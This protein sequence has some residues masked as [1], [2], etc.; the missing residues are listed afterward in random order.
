MKIKDYF[1]VA[2]SLIKAKLF[3]RRLPIVVNWAI[4]Y[5]CN[6]RCLYCGIRNISAEEINRNQVFSFI[7]EM[8]QMGTRRI[9]FTGGEPLLREDIGEILEYSKGKNIK[10][11]L[12]SNG[13]LVPE[14]INL[15]KSLDLLSLSLDGDEEVQDTIRQEGSYQKV[16]EAVE[17]AR[18]SNLKIRIITVI[19]KV[20]LNSVDF[21]IDKANEIGAFVT[22]Q[23]ATKMLLEAD[24]V[25][26]IAPSRE[27]YRKVI[28]K[29]ISKKKKGYSIGNSISG[30][31]YLSH[32]P[33]LAGI[34]CVNGR[35][36]CRLEPDGRLYGCGNFKSKNLPLSC[37]K[38]GFK[39]AFD[40]LMPV[41]CK[42]CWCAAMVEMNYLFS[43]RP[44]AVLNIL[45]L[46]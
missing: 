11:A 24:S 10:T 19:S 22:F 44:D 46:I 45:K 42:E 35:V 17:A 33:Y 7:D 20:N 18:A 32:W 21:I 27:E 23:P 26:P 25:N 41:S 43:F 34:A 37:T 38:S 14:K 5:R 16:M 13:F 2:V 4:T 40:N 8:A 31:M 30:L 29:L 1:P 28:K 9:H 39:R 12:N 15:L 6:Y 3:N 36:I